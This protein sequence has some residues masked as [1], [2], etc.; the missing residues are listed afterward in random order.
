VDAARPTPEAWEIEPELRIP[1]PRRTRLSPF[2]RFCVVL[3]VAMPV[4]SLLIPLVVESR[5]GYA[6]WTWG[7]S[8]ALAAV[9]GGVMWLLLGRFLRRQ[10]RIL[11]TWRAVPA[12]V[13]RLV[14]YGGRA[15][16]VIVTADVEVR[17]GE[18]R[19]AECRIPGAGPPGLVEGTTLTAL[20]G[21]DGARI[22][23]YA[24]VRQYARVVT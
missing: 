8:I 1:P 18:V 11:A 17:P 14:R 4:P 16:A 6:A 7:F 13:V 23:L 19:R 12:R 2:G 15:S 5:P 21:D 24:A 22:E 10:R 3:C 20:V 9:V